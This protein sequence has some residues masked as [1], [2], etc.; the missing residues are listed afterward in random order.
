MGKPITDDFVNYGLPLDANDALLR[1]TILSE[2]YLTGAI[3]KKRYKKA[4][5]RIA[6]DVI[7]TDPASFD[8]LGSDTIGS[9]H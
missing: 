1:Q 6:Q 4:T 8:R 7:P 2:L 5:K 3:S 9:P